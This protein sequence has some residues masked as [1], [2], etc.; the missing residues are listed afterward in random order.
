MAKEQKSKAELYREERKARIAKASKGKKN[1]SISVGVNTASDK[2]DKKIAIGVVAVLAV[3]LV[4]WL[5]NFLGIPQRLNTVMTVGTEKVSAAEYT[6]Y[7]RQ[8]YLSTYQQSYYI[9][10]Q[11][12]FNLGFDYTKSP[13]EQEYTGSDM[14]ANEDGSNPTWAD[15]FRKTAEENITKIKTLC[16][17]A[18]SLGISLDEEDLKAIDDDIEELRTSVADE[19]NGQGVSLNVYF[20]N[21]YGSGV[22]EKFFRELAEQEALAQKVSEAKSEEFSNALTDDEINTYYDENK[23]TYDLVDIAVFPIAIDEDAETPVT[24]DDAKAKAEEMLAKV[25]DNDS[26]VKYAQE[27]AS[28]DDKET[29]SEASA[30]VFDFISQENLTST[31][32]EEVTEWA[33]SEDRK[34]GDKTVITT[35]TAAYVV[36]L[37]SA[38]YRDDSATVDVRHILFKYEDGATDEQK[39][40][41]DAKAEELYN[42]WK[43]GDATEASFSELAKTD[44]EDS[45]ASDGGLIENISKGQTVDAFE[46][47]CFDESRKPGDSG[48]IQTEYG[49]HIM[50]FVEKNDEPLWKTN[51]KSTL[52]SEK[53][54]DYY[55]ELKG[56]DANKVEIKENKVARLV[57]K[58]SKPAL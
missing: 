30:T 55:E 57:K 25:K 6:Y 39:A 13:D 49:A 53:F 52:A 42:T 50:Y 24:A 8:T 47:W 27:Y 29:Y 40:E 26:F 54:N 18:E 31:A 32:S 51:I 14:E 23:D 3:V 34:D 35:D 22:N 16:A 58:I 56:Q 15:Y 10:S 2:T 21:N 43:N 17:Q 37:N 20:R 44:S 45:S 33:F 38:R 7:Y 11:Y 5:V 46:N 4:V 9:Q 28:E 12:G 48:V 19:E 41:I 36:L 1:G